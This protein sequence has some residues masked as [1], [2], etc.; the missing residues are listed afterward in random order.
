M[1][2]RTV[3]TVQLQLGA[4]ILVTVGVVAAVD[5]ISNPNSLVLGLAAAAIA[6]AAAL[7]VPWHRLPFYATAL[8]PAIDIVAIG[9]LRD[10]RRS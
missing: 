5:A 2:T 10:S 4:V 3:R 6:T 7:L 8:V 1:S 9:L